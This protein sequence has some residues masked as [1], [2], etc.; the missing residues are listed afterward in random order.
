MFQFF[1]LVLEKYVQGALPLKRIL[2]YQVQTL[3]LFDFAVLSKIRIFL[4]N[5]L[6]GE[7]LERIISR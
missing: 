6:Q 1:K 4:Q 7:I 3:K 5:Q 2:Q